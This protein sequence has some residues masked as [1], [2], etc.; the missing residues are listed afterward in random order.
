[1]QNPV[2]TIEKYKTSPDSSTYRFRIY[3]NR[4]V[5]FDAIQNQQKENEQKYQL[6][7]EEYV[8]LLTVFEN[9]GF[10]T[11]TGNSFRNNMAITSRITGVEKT[12]TFSSSEENVKFVRALEVALKSR[13]L[14][15]P[16]DKDDNPMTMD[17][18][19]IRDGE[20][21]KERK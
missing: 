5:V 12:V 21:F 18:C 10:S 4:T 3:N 19:Q 14:Q 17:M 7:T 6:S 15:C 20:I 13:K 16:S 1:M 9:F 2:I 8:N 11:L